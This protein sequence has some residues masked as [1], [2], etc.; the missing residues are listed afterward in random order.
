MKKTIKV[1]SLVL[2][3]VMIVACATSLV[4]CAGDDN[5]K[6]VIGGI[7]PL[8]G[9]Y[10]NYGTSVKNGAQIAIEE[11]GEVNGIKLEL[12][13]EDSKGDGTEAVKAYGTLMDKGMNVSLGGVLS[14]ETANIV[15]EAKNDGIFLLTPSASAD[16]CIDGNDDAFRVCFADSAQ[17]TAS[18]NY[19]ADNEI[20]TKVAV[21][22][23]SDIDYSKG[24]YGT[25]MATAEERGIEVVTEQSFTK[26]Q[27]TDFS[28]Q[29]TAIKDS[30]AE[31]IFAPIYAAE[32]STFLIQADTKE[33]D[34]PV[35]GCDGLDGI[36]GKVGEGNE[37]FA[38]GVMM[39][40]PFS[41]DSA[42]ENVK[43][44]VTTYK[45]KYD[46]VPDQFAAS[47]YDAVYI[48]A[49]AIKAAE[50]TVDDLSDVDALG[51]KITAQILK[52]EYKGVTGTMTWSEDGNTSKAALAMIIEEVD[53]NYVTSIYTKD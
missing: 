35:F 39:L 44:F 30:G 14:G 19:I 27:N 38:E 28:S 42:D 51:A 40:T 8:T 3:L 46:A 12:L 24:L 1:L 4:G 32:C 22:Y 31:L 5:D 13:F 10:A 43:S 36:L 53:G 25:F 47:G 6:I 23:Q 11:I 34:V 48:I 41:A 50:I 29:I 37:K 45:E 16:K 20:A 9:D 2:S 15:A 21:F 7:G 33:L 26:D 18:A 49:E 52:L 17:G